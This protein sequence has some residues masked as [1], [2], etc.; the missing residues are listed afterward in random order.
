MPSVS[1]KVQAQSL[2][3]CRLPRNSW[4]PHIHTGSSLAG[5]S[6]RGMFFKYLFAGDFLAG[7]LIVSYRSTVAWRVLEEDFFCIASLFLEACSRYCR[8]VL[9]VIF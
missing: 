8:H 9:F 3:T 1:G 2:R 6:R 7:S 4:H 5:F